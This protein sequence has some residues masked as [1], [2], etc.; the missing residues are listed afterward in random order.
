VALGQAWKDL[1]AVCV[2]IADQ[3]ETTGNYVW[4][5]DKIKEAGETAK[6]DLVKVQTEVTALEAD[7]TA[8]AVTGKNSLKNLKKLLKNAS[9]AI[10]DLS[11]ATSDED[12]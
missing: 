8:K 2:T 12:A 6:A 7:A 10:E 3:D 9:K 11:K 4:S 5:K 1:N